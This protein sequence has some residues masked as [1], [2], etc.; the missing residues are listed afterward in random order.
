MEMATQVLIAHTGQRLQI[1]PAQFASYYNLNLNVPGLLLTPARL[2]DFKSSIAQQSS[3]P[4]H[5]INTLTPQG[6]PL[7]LQNIKTEVRARSL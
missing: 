3:I 7:K 5:S 6:K 4:I 1:D 2:D